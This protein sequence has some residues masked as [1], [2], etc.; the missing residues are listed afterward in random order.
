MNKRPQ[1]YPATAAESRPWLEQVAEVWLEQWK[2]HQAV[3]PHRYKIDFAAFV[4]ERLLTDFELRDIE[5]KV[6]GCGDK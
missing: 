3:P 4:G 6:R 1:Q 5:R 2:N